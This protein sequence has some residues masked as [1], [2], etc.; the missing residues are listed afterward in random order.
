MHPLL[1]KLVGN[2]SLLDIPLFDGRMGTR[3]VCIARGRVEGL[4]LLC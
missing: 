1:I 2:V 4:C 3:S